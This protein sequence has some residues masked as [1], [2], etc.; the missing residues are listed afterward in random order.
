LKYSNIPKI[1]IG[2]RY[3]IPEE[4]FDEWMVKNIGGRI[5][6]NKNFF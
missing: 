5:Q 2:K 4:S 1:I 3:Y 6:I